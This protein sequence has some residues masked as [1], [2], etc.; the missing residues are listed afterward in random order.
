[1]IIIS[2]EL[3]LELMANKKI[4]NVIK[5]DAIVSIEVVGGYYH[6]VYDLTS[7]LLDRQ[8]NV[9]QT[10]I[11]IDTPGTPLTIDEA[12]IQTFMMLLKSIEDATE[13]DLKNL[14]V[15]HTLEYNDEEEEPAKDPS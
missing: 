10:L 8:E 9:T 3:I 7:R 1:M 15:E 5:E 12:A 6:R 11:N 2:L 13:K 4:V 14:T